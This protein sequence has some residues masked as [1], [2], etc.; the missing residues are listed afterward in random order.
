MQSFLRSFFLVGGLLAAGSWAGPV[1]VRDVDVYPLGVGSRA[2]QLAARGLDVP[3]YLQERG[4]GPM[5]LG[6]YSLQTYHVKKV[7]F[8]L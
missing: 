6:N 2:G 5:I 8:D 3:L 4:A 1:V 7:L